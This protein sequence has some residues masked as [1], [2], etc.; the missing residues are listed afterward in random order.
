[1]TA[2]FINHTPVSFCIETKGSR[3]KGYFT[4]R[5]AVRAP[6]AENAIIN[7]KVIGA[8]Q[9]MSSYLPLPSKSCQCPKGGAGRSET[10]TH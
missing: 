3:K 8:S 7:V 1:M 9:E 2:T 4:V 6:C 10:L 5:L